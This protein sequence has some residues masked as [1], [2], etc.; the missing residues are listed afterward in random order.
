MVSAIVYATA[1]ELRARI[2]GRTDTDDTTLDALLSATSR[3]WDA[4]CGRTEDGFKAA[5]SATAREFVS[6]GDS[7]LYI[8]ECMEITAAGY[9]NALTDTSYTALSSGDWRGF[10]GAP[11]SRNVRYGITPYHGMMLTPA[12]TLTRFLSGIYD[13]DTIPE[14]TVQVTARW[15]HADTTPPVVVEATI[16]QSTIFYKRGKGGWADVLVDAELGSQRFVRQLDPA[17]KLLLHGSRLKRS[18]LVGR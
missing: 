15:G 16:A 10:R 13:K 5:E 2:G 4:Y 12:S 14:P 8:D 1:A 17:L 9:K 7:W 6:A 3:L 11:G 18:V